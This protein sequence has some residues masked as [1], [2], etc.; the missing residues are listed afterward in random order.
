MKTIL[1]VTRPILPPWN[2]GSKNTAWQI[3]QRAK[4]HYFHLMSARSVKQPPITGSV[5]WKYVY[6][7]RNFLASQKLRL[8]WHLVQKNPDIDIYHFLFVP[9]LTSSRL[10]SGIVHLRRKLSIQTVP[11]LH[12]KYIS[13]KVAQVLLF[14][15]KI[16]VL[17]DWTANKL[18]SLG[19][20][21]IA[22]INM[23]IDRERFRPVQNPDDM[24]TKFGLPTGV[25]LALF[26][27]ELSRL[28][29][30]KSLLS[31]IPDVLKENSAIHFVLASPLRLQE[32]IAA[33]KR[34]QQAIHSLDLDTS[35]HF[36]DEV[37]DFP[38]LLNACDMLVFPVEE[39]LGKIDTPLTVLEAMA[40][41]LPIIITDVPPLNEVL[42]A[43]AGIALPLGDH[44]G[45][46]QAILELAQDG[47]VRRQM[48][49]AG[50]KVIESHF[51]L[52]V[53]VKAYED[54]YDELS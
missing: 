23:G 21:N 16:I 31:I 32:D 51:D 4:Q 29:S 43:E 6:T 34:T 7:D 39:M 41:E 30:T 14:A 26:S 2:E 52:Q 48:G 24:R 11:N 46:V 53:M 5:I 13:P 40:T 28:G 20:K 9:T 1:M 47:N 17:S 49:Y 33:K 37:D 25:P 38:S 45:F 15:D 3:A 35:V 19:I 54:L 8:V 27:G 44:K 36:L 10:L 12:A 18:Q 22:R 42:K 50:R